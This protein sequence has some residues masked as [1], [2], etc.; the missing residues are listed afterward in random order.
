MSERSYSQACQIFVTVPGRNRLLAAASGQFDISMTRT[1]FCEGAFS[2]TGLREW[3]TLPHYITD[4]TNREIFKR[5]TNYF[6]LA[7]NY[8]F[9]TF[10]STF[11]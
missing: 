1:V 7:A 9:K 10:L 2:M 5:A 8:D 11:F 3:N 4:I 6:K